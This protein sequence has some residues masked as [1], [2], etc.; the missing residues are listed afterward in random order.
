MRV[1]GVNVK[2][3]FLFVVVLDWAADGEAT[4]T[5]VASN[6]FEA[7]G[8]L[9]D[10]DRFSDLRDRIRQFLAPLGV[11]RVDVVETRQYAQWKYADAYSR[12]VK[13][14]AVMDASRAL[15][16]PFSTQ[17]TGD[18]AKTLN[19]QASML[20]VFE[21]S[22]VGLAKNPMYWTTGLSEAAAV[23]L[24]VLGDPAAASD[25]DEAEPA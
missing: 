19:L 9:G 6:R 10:A 17:K 5:V 3:G 22:R 24:H 16:V 18:I 12:V 21:A 4:P 2:A 8:S 13:I 25:D 14:C 7:N 15:G 23:G 20:Q 11:S 1:A